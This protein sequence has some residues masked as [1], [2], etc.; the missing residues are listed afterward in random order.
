M[1]CAFATSMFAAI[2]DGVYDKEEDL[3][4]T[5][6]YQNNLTKNYELELA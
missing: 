1:Y 5:I 2:V 3:H 6:S 4:K